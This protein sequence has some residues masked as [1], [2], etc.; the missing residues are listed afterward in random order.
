MIDSESNT[1]TIWTL[2]ISLIF[3]FFN[4]FFE[5]KG[6]EKGTKFLQEKTKLFL[7][8]PTKVEYSIKSLIHM[9][10]KKR[11]ILWYP[12][13]ILFMCNF[14]D[15]T[16]FESFHWFSL[17]SSFYWASKRRALFCLQFSGRAGR[18]GGPLNHV[19]TLKNKAEESSI[20]WMPCA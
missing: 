6:G 19:A 13:E 16:L 9:L 1:L 15:F 8:Q 3:N 20:F 10:K 14:K 11:Q 12:I 2:T 4:Q 5:G 17:L 7:T 18:H